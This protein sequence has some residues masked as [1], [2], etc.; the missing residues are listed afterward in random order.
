MSALYPAAV[1]SLLDH[2]RNWAAYPPGPE[3]LFADGERLSWPELDRR[4]QRTA[5]FLRET[6]GL[7]RGAHVGLLAQN[8]GF[9]FELAYACFRAGLVLAPLNYR[10]AAAEL[11]PLLALTHP[12]VLFFDAA[13]RATV[14]ALGDAGGLRRLAVEAYLADPPPA[15]PATE[16]FVGTGYDEPALLLCTSGTTGRPKAAVLPARQLFWNAVNSGLAWALTRYDA[17]LLY[18]PLFHTGAINVLAFPLLHAGG[19]VVLHR[20]FDAQRIL[21]DLAAERISVVF[22]VP[23]TLQLLSAEPAFPTADLAGLRLVLSGGA[24]L[25]LSLIETYRERGLVLTQGFGMTEVGPNCFY[26]PQEQAL[27]RAGAV[28]KPMPGTAARLVV[29]GREAGAGEV[30]ELWLHGPHVCLGYLA[31]PTATAEA[32]TADG[33]FRTGDLARR[34]ADGF[35]YIAGRQKEM[36]IS[37]GENVYPAEVE[38]ALAGHPAVAECAVVS[39]PDARWGEVGCA[40]VVAR[41]GATP[42]DPDDLRTFLRTRLAGYKV[43]RAFVLCPALPRNASGKLLKG[44]LKEEALAHVR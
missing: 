20:A 43:P 38:G 16:P 41:A 23:T 5:V 30:G 32:L 34:D 37:G 33:W 26:L 40:F 10:L 13:N 24:P 29:D 17:T 4:A 28:G 27:A 14:E 39:M 6:L 31:N 9:F 1:P 11:Q 8:G 35:F 2:P 19:R 42:P 44:V 25:P 15:R 21:S 22:G 18:T 7:P 3:A 36:F 12:G